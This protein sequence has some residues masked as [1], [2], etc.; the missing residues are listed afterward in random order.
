MA[1]RQFNY[2]VAKDRR[3]AEQHQRDKIGAAFAA[4]GKAIA[5]RFSGASVGGGGGG[6]GPGQNEAAFRINPAPQRV[7]PRPPG[8]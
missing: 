4:F 5:G 2:M 8:K 1:E 3:A 7:P 6:G